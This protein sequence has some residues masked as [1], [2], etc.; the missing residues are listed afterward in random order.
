M[1][2]DTSKLDSEL[3]SKAFNSC[4]MHKVHVRHGPALYTHINNMLK[5]DC[6]QAGPHGFSN[7]LLCIVLS[8]VTALYIS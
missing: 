8:F 7:K 4:Y 3:T 1:S 6:L 2:P 5:A